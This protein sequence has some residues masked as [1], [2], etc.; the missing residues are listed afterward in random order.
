MI[1]YIQVGANCGSPNDIMRKIAAQNNWRGVLVEPMPS[2]YEQLKINCPNDIVVH[3][4]ITNK[5]EP[6]IDMYYN[7]EAQYHRR[8]SIFSKM[9]TK[10]GCAKE[11]LAKISV[12][13]M[14][15]NELIYKYTDQTAFQMLQI[16]AE[17]YDD[18]IIY[19]ANLDRYKFKEI[20]F[21]YCHLTK[22]ALD[23][24]DAFLSARGYFDKPDIYKSLDSSNVLMDRLYECKNF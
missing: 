4:A 19:S 15:L 17:G 13:A 2:S 5:I 7:S 16:D 1:D 22:D 14:S 23:D 18:C 20:R 21:E 6:T 3:A 24:L 8:A 9:L 12:P 10:H 11:N